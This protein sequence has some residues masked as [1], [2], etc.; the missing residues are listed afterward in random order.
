MHPAATDALYFV[1]RGDGT[2]EFSGRS[3]RTIRPS[4]AF[5]ASESMN[6]KLITLEGARAPARAPCSGGSRPVGGARHDVLVTRGPAG[7]PPAGDSRRLARRQLR[8]LCAETE[9]LLMLPRARSW[10][11]R[12]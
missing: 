5:N 4:R 1:A 12:S 7:R 2:H 3:M 9:L 8:G 11:A 6:G 10:C